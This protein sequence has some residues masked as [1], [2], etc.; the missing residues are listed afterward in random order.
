MASPGFDIDI[1]TGE[2][3]WQTKEF[4][5]DGEYSWTSSIVYYIDKYNVRLPQRFEQKILKQD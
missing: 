4:M 5:N 3:I 2:K 1:L